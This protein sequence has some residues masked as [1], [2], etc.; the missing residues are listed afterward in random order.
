MKI[1]IDA[2]LERKDPQ[3]RFLDGDTDDVLMHWGPSFTRHLMEC[4][5]LV[6]EELFRCAGEGLE[7]LRGFLAELVHGRSERL[8]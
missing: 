6:P 5:D 2:W 4:G 1:V 7:A 3:V 8:Q